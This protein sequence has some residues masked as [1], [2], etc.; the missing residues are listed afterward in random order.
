MGPDCRET[1]TIIVA[2]SAKG[3][4]TRGVFTRAQCHPVV[5]HSQSSLASFLPQPLCIS[6][7]PLFH[8][9]PARVFSCSAHP[10]LATLVTQNQRNEGLD[11]RSALIS[12]QN[13][14]LS[15]QTLLS[16]TLKCLSLAAATLRCCG[17]RGCYYSDSGPLEK[18][19]NDRVG[20]VQP[21][22]MS[23]D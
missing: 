6:R 21:C 2:D 10:P 18:V 14:V 3:P 23:S 9:L 7:S 16:C 17:D 22:R 12:H 15:C 20:R 11:T 13:S 4:A 5:R 1:F 8:S 19:V